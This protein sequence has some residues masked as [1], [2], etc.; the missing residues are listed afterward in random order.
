MGDGGIVGAH[1]LGSFGLDPH[2]RGLDAE[3]V[4]DLL[5]NGRRMGSDLRS[6]QNQRAV[7]I[8]D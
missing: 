1:A 6:G 2:A 8:A 3:Q 5:L 4:R 7:H